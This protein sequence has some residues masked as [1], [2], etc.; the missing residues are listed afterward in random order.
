METGEHTYKLILLLK[1]LRSVDR[2]SIFSILY[3]AW[4]TFIVGIT[5]LHISIY[6]IL[7]TGYFLSDCTRRLMFAFL[8]YVIWLIIYD[9]M[10]VLPNHF[11]SNIHIKDVYMLER[12]L[13]GIYNGSQKITLNEYFRAHHT[14]ILDV[15]S[16]LCYINW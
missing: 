7:I 6:L 13:F 11:V 15:L 4:F 5:S 14:P 12:K 9:S 10:R 1:T 8:I 16:G 3:F 2:I